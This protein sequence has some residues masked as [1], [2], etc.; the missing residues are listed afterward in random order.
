MLCFDFDY[1]KIFDALDDAGVDYVVIG[2]LAAI[3]HGSIRFTSD[4]DIA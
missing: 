3:A 2:G 4:A 1:S